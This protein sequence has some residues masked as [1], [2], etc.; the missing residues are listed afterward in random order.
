MYERERDITV[1]Y[2]GTVVLLTGALAVLKLRGT[3]QASWGLITAPIWLSIAALA[4]I[5]VVVGLMIIALDE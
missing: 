4:A 5:C 3:T 1:I 2:I